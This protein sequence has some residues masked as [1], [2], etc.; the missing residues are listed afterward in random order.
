VLVFDGVSERKVR[1]D[2]VAV[3]PPDPVAGDISGIDEIS[4]DALRGSFRDANPLGQVASSDLGVL[5]DADEHMRVVAQERPRRPIA[6]LWHA[7]ATLSDFDPD[8]I[9]FYGSYITILTS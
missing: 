3:P 8:R 2:L 4:D 5:G 9:T 6:V 1:V 7:D